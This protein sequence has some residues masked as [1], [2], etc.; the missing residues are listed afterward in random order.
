VPDATPIDDAVAVPDAVAA[1]DV[2][3]AADAV[4][5]PEPVVTVPVV[6]AVA[7]EAVTELEGDAVP[8]PE[9]VVTESVADVAMAPETCQSTDQ[10]GGSEAVLARRES[11]GHPADCEFGMVRESLLNFVDDAVTEALEFVGDVY[12]H[13][14]T[15]TPEVS[16]ELDLTVHGMMEDING[17]LEANALTAYDAHHEPS[18]PFSFLDDRIA[19]VAKNGK[20]LQGESSDH[21]VPPDGVL[22]ARK[23]SN[24][25]GM[26]PPRRK[27]I[28]ARTGSFN[29]TSHPEVQLQWSDFVVADQVEQ[30]R[31]NA[32]SNTTSGP[33]PMLLLLL[34]K[35]IKLPCGSYVILSA[36][37]RPLE[38]GN[39][40]LRV[41]FYDS[42]RMEE[43][44]Y[45]FSE[46]FLRDFGIHC[47]VTSHDEVKQF[48]MRLHCRR[49][50]G[51]VIIQLP[52]RIPADRA[53][54]PI[55]PPPRTTPAARRASIACAPI[56]EYRG[57]ED[58][59]ATSD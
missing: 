36:F 59:G 14:H 24:G 25:D 50:Q 20:H 44:Q 19:N 5:E 55:E 15:R 29:P 11:I 12:D 38:D 18:Q 49:E 46:D 57:E 21:G 3:P 33:R 53:H 23:M 28:S 48:V 10:H 37:I 41:Q 7:D 47:G 13:A 42:E 22:V 2:V 16:S 43:F 40:N 4:P 8:E 26:S 1:D 35:G 30:S 6:D 54:V 45:D 58:V 39:E 56:P 17:M 31:E 32:G 27:S 52:A 34:K 9:P 51:S